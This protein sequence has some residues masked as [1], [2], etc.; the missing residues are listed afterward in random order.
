MKDDDSNT[1][2]PTTTVVTINW[3]GLKRFLNWQG[4]I[5]ELKKLELERSD[6]PP[7]RRHSRR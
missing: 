2:L 4:S 7:T 6:L 1:K 3:E 5:S